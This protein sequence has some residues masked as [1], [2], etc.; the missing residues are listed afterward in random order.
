MKKREYET[1]GTSPEIIDTTTHF[2]AS[3]RS[4]DWCNLVELLDASKEFFIRYGGHRQAAGFTISGDKLDAFRVH[5][6]SEFEKRYDSAK[7]P[8]KTINVECILHPK[9]VSLE[10]LSSIDRFRPFGIGNAKPL[11][12]LEHLTIREVREIGTEK[13]HLS[14]TFTEIPGVK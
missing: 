3:C 13:N 7:L 12:L 1:R 2:V 9:D 6:R 11:F 5:I 8:Q 10:T 14:L 4:P